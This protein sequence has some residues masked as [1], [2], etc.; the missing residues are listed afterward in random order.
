[1]DGENTI[2]R[3]ASAGNATSCSARSARDG[4]SAARLR[5]KWVLDYLALLTGLAAVG[6]HPR[7]S[8][9]LLAYLSG[10]I[11]GMV[12]I[13]RAGSVSSRRTTTMLVLAG[14]PA[15]DASLAVLAYRLVSYAAAHRRSARDLRLPT[16][17]A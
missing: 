10:A 7:P 8:L 1:V 16:R 3:T 17:F 14:V 5:G 4:G 6:A 13:R 11:L 12:P 2:S 15:G 9:V